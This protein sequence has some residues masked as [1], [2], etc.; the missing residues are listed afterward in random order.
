MQ[1]IQSKITTGKAKRAKTLSENDITK[2]K[3]LADVQTSIWGN[4]L[5]DNIVT[6]LVI[7]LSDC[8]LKQLEHILSEIDLPKSGIKTAKIKRLIDYCGYEWKEMFDNIVSLK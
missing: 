2:L 7:C 6:Y 8:D 5:I 4:E 1:K 3:Q